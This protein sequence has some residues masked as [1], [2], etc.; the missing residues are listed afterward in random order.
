MERKRPKYVEYVQ[1]GLK[2]TTSVTLQDGIM[3]FCLWAVQYTTGLL[4]CL[5][6][7]NT[8]DCA[9]TVWLLVKSSGI[10]GIGAVEPA[11]YCTFIADLDDRLCVVK[12]P[13]VSGYVTSSEVAGISPK[14]GHAGLQNGV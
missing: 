3:D 2:N 5:Y 6:P 7:R 11:E 9:M 10:G 12:H 13:M 4:C 8:S 14:E 1:R